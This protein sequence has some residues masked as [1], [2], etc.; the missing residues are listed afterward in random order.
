M[1]KISVAII[2]VASIILLCRVWYHEGYMSA[3][4]DVRKLLNNNRKEQEQ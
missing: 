4:K 3:L 1:D 2:I